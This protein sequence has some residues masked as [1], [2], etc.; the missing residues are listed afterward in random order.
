MENLVKLA[1]LTLTE[2]AQDTE[3]FMNMEKRL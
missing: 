3:M 1:N 2:Y